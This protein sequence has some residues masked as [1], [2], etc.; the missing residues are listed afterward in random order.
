MLRAH[1]HLEQTVDTTHREL[2]ACTRGPGGGLLL[3]LQG[4]LVRPVHG[5]LGTLPGQTLGALS[6]HGCDVLWNGTGEC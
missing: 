1:P 4:L 5:A 3:V 6:A 2:Q